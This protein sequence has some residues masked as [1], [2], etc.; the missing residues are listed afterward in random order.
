[1]RSFKFVRLISIMAMIAI[2]FVSCDAIAPTPFAPPTPPTLMKTADRFYSA[3][4]AAKDVEFKSNPTDAGKSL[5]LNGLN[6]KPCSQVVYLPFENSFNHTTDVVKATYVTTKDMGTT[7]AMIHGY[8][9]IFEVGEVL[10]GEGLSGKLY[11]TDITDFSMRFAK[12][13]EYVLLLRRYRSTYVQDDLYSFSGLSRIPLDE[14][15]DADLKRAEMLHYDMPFLETLVEDEL[16]AAVENGDFI[17]KMVEMISNVGYEPDPLPMDSD[18][19]ETV[20]SDADCVAVITVGEKQGFPSGR[21]FYCERY[22]CQV[23]EVLKGDPPTEINVLLPTYAVETG[24]QY[25][26]TLTSPSLNRNCAPS[27]RYFMFETTEL[28]PVKAMLEYIDAK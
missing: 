25:I 27:G 20:L 22:T 13:E 12:G 1:M 28:E 15:G 17:E 7:H 6:I 14:N 23:N 3:I 26:V 16:K 19:P 24:E 11:V 4:D 2:F 21:E 9:H 18:D 8:C 10:Y 5:A